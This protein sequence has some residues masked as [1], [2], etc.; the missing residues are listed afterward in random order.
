MA[1][2]VLTVNK[3][4][5]ANVAFKLNLEENIERTFVRIELSSETDINLIN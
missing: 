5:P 3:T 1:A 4:T 2:V